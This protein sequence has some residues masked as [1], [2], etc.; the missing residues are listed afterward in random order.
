MSIF[1]KIIRKNT[2]NEGKGL[3]KEEYEKLKVE[4]P[5]DRIVKLSCYDKIYEKKVSYGYCVTNYFLLDRPLNVEEEKAIHTLGEEIFIGKIV[6]I[7]GENAGDVYDL[8]LRDFREICI[9]MKVS[10]GE[11]GSGLEGCSMVKKYKDRKY[12][13]V[14]ELKD[15]ARTATDKS[16]NHAREDAYDFYKEW[17]CSR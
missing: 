12:I 10:A 7:T 17:G 13:T 6:Q 5:L 16:K 14:G 11:Y 1:K 2:V 8:V 4:L 3:L 15:L 9:G